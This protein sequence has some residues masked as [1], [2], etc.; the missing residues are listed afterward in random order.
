[1]RYL[2]NK[3][4]TIQKYLI[5]QGKKLQSNFPETRQWGKKHRHDPIEFRVV[6]WIVDNT[7]RQRFYTQ[8]DAI[9]CGFQNGLKKN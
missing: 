6:F 4:H 5:L 7:L 2:H 8:G 3:C 9:M 1:M